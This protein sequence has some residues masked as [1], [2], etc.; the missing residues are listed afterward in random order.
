MSPPLCGRELYLNLKL[1]S[2]MALLAASM[3]DVFVS[4]DQRLGVK[5]EADSKDLRTDS[6]PMQ[7]AELAIIVFLVEENS[8]V[9]LARG[10]SERI[11]A[12]LATLATLYI[13]ILKSATE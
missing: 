9:A 6:V 4:S 13:C 11:D 7:E 1:L 12:A 3:A 10:C 2:L 5:T 8:S